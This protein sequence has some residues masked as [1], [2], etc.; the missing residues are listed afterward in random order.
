MDK[1]LLETLNI[2]CKLIFGRKITQNG[3]LAEHSQNEGDF[4]S[5]QE[6]IKMYLNSN[7][8]IMLGRFGTTELNTFLNY[9]QVSGKNIDSEKFSKINYIFDRCLPNFFTRR[10]KIL[11]SNLSGFF[12]TTDTELLKWGDRVFDDL[13]CLDALFIWQESEKY[14][15]TYLKDKD[16]ILCS[17]MYY[18]YLFKNPW[19]SVL[20][21]KK[22]LV[23]SPFA[24]LIKEQYT[25]KRELLFKDPNVLPLFKSLETITAYNVLGGNNCY[26]NINSWME[27][28]IDMEK[29]M[30]NLDYEIAIIGCGAYAFDLAAYAKRSGKKA[31]TMC[32]SL[33][34]LFGIYGTRYEEFLK[35]NGILNENWIRPGEKFKPKGYEKVEHGAYW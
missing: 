13:K 33:Q 28:L 30:D 9:L 22:V 14:I 35:D 16:K 34:V 10:N 19:T 6:K 20:K 24:E 23:I 4:S 25:N 3:R 18:P 2:I 8:P 11:M 27:A 26:S 15:K 17:D 5:E 31:I 12:P 32:G 1:L 29:Q 7:R 21:G